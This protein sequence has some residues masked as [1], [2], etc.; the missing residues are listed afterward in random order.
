MAC[1]RAAGQAGRHDVGR[2]HIA[3]GVL[4]VLVDADALEAELVGQFELV[5]I[6]VIERMAELRI[7][8][9]VGA[10]HPGTVVALS[11]VL[12]QVSPRH[13]VKAEKA[14]SISPEVSRSPR[15]CRES[16]MWVAV[17]V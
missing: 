2:G 3:V 15:L 1:C 16:R 11:K 5:Q 6:A 9:R 8:E 7:V 10:G 17:R 4:V 14:H 13:Q 12:G